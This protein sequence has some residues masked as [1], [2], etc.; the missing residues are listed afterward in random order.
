MV[1]H[2]E[3]HRQATASV[4][5]RNIITSM[6]LISNMNWRDLFE[7]IS[8]VDEALAAG[9]GFSDMDFTTR[10]FYRSAIEELARSSNWTEIEIAQKVVLAC[11]AAAFTDA[12]M[13]KDRRSDPGYYLLGSGRRAF[14]IAIGYRPPLDVRLGRWNQP[15]GIGG[16]LTPI[17]I[18]AAGLLGLTLF[19]LAAEGVAGSWLS[20]LGVL[21]AIPA[22]DAA[23][24]LVNRDVAR[25]FG[26]TLLPALEL[27]DGVPAE[28]RTMVVIP[29]ML[30]S[31][32]TIEDLVER[33][34]V[35]HLAS[36][37]GDLYFALL[38]DWCDADTEN[39]EGDEDLL[40]CCG[41]RR[42][43]TQSPPR[44]RCGRGALLAAASQ[45]N[46]ECR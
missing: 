35:H 42:R 16:Y 15:A 39:V 13:D 3:H 38:S 33:L 45:E 14:E 2:D 11:E 34:E 43:G 36:L 22:I 41:K 9:N 28:L 8:L 20:L 21:G 19:Y 10:N 6:R 25:G 40:C 29:M 30:T 12:K 46:L 24:A 31:I 37:E 5:V 32:E 23:V 27:R 18:A 26:A 4:T 7:R 44:T 17:G 1:V